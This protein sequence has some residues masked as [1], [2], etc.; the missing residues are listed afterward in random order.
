VNGD[1]LRDLAINMVQAPLDIAG[2]GVQVGCLALVLGRR[3]FPPVLEFA[4]LPKVYGKLPLLEGATSSI[5]FSTDG[6]GDFDG[7]GFDDIALRAHSIGDEDEG[8]WGSFTSWFLLF[9]RREW[10]ASSVLDDELETGGA[11]E[12]IRL[13]LNVYKSDC[14]ATIVSIGDEDR[15]GK[16]DLGV[17]VTITGVASTVEDFRLLHGR[18]RSALDHP[19]DPRN[20]DDFDVVFTLTPGAQRRIVSIKRGGRDMSGDGIPDILIAEHHKDQDPPSRAI[21]VFGG[22]LAGREGPL[23][24]LS[25]TQFVNYD[26]CPQQDSLYGCYFPG[27]LHFGGDVNGDRREDL[28]IADLEKVRICFNPLGP[29]D[30]TRAFRRGDSNSDGAFDLSDA[31]GALGFLFLGES[32]PACIDAADADDGEALT[33][34]D[35]IRLLGWLYLGNEP[36]APP[37]DCGPDPEGTALDCRASACN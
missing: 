22:G 4:G 27:G 23:D 32:E 36:P 7:D 20:R 19:I 35:A 9:G 16:D 12:L 15:D 18:S 25:G 5:S 24:S 31:V 21:V 37:R 30:R 26:D 6:V 14:G 28:V 33:I 17:T 1:G 13:Y 3:Q 2:T 34:T 8:F 11:K 10:A 29:L